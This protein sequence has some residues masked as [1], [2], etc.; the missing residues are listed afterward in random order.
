M[1]VHFPEGVTAAS[2]QGIEIKPDSSNQA[3]IPESLL[4]HFRSVGF[5]LVVNSPVKEPIASP[6][7]EEV[8][9]VPVAPTQDETSS[10]KSYKRETL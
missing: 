9:P 2:A 1:K 4:H 5:K 8:P 10:K 3:E 7:S 6:I